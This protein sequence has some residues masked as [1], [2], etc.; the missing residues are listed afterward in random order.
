MTVINLEKWVASEQAPDRKIF[1]QA[2]RLLL[3]SIANSYRL[4]PLMVMKGGILLAI[5]YNS[6]RFT[7][8][9]DFSTTSTFNEVEVPAFLDDL[10]QALTEITADNEYGLAL[11]IQSHRINPPS[12]K[13]PT[14]PTLKIKVGYANL[15]DSS[16]MRQLRAKNAAKTIAIDYSYNEWSTGIEHQSLD[17]GDLS[18]Y[19]L[20]DLI[21]E[22]Y[23]SVLQQ[24]LRNRKRFQDIYDLCLLLQGHKF[25]K[26]DQLMILEKLHHACKGRNLSLSRLSLRDPLIIGLSQEDYNKELPKLLS[27]QPPAFDMA[28]AVVQEF[29]EKLPW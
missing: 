18:M 20:H 23:R 8:D 10:E 12:E 28:Y 5:R 19:A 14:F 13:Q 3:R 29:Y 11:K 1:R 27:S 26:D 9:V 15:A 7:Q 24:A 17:G 25:S 16:Q 2:T 4:A 22:K 6:E 21:A